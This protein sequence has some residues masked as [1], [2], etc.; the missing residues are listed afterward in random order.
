[1]TAYAAS[2]LAVNAVPKASIN[3][4]NSSVRVSNDDYAAR[5]RLTDPHRTDRT[6]D[7]AGERPVDPGE[8]ARPPIGTR[9]MR[10]RGK[11]ARHIRLFL[12]G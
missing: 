10:D 2:F 4:S 9:Q 8:R 11:R 5:A 6:G 3:G 7:D 1:M 12:R